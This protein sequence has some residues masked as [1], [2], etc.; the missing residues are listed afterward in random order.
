MSKI[1]VFGA[2]GFIGRNL[3][4][5]LASNAGN[6]IVAFDRFSAYQVGSDHPFEKYD[7]LTIMAGNFFNRNEVS[8]ALKDVDYVFHLI[9]TT[10]P[11][12]SDS[13]PFIDVDTNVRSSIELFQL[14]TEH[15]VKKVIFL[16]SGGTVYGDID[17]DGIDELT[18]PLPRSPY[19]I[20]KLTIEHFLRYFKYK[21]GLD[22]VIYRVSNPY[23]PGQNIYGK[24][25]VIPIFMNRYLTKEPLTIFGDGSMVR[26]YIYIDDLIDLI[27]ATYSKDNV[28]NE[29][30]LG[31]GKGV[32]VNELVE[33][34]EK[35]T[36]FSIQK[37]SVPTPPTY[38][39]TSV[40]DIQRFSKEFGMQPTTTLED[41][42]ART[43]D[44]VKKLN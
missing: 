31:S 37:N 22:Y 14:C 3:V 40:L 20:G 26:D 8:A 4:A 21:D 29:Y 23:G 10:N 6:T 33:A 25:G 42:I 11:A 15:K 39:H 44:Y 9:S 17:K 41:G 18:V 16:S 35:Q 13:D 36:G 2:D 32:A 30:N 38:I 5:N 34:I 43:W 7:N 19:G 1:A 27:I 12:T 28:H 24:Q